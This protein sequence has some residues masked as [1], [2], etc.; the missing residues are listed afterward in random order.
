[1]TT[2]GKK[3]NVFLYT[4]IVGFVVFTLVRIRLERGY[5]PQT[6][7]TV[8]DPTGS[9]WS[10]NSPETPPQTLDKDDNKN[11]ALLSSK[12]P[13]SAGDQAHSS[14]S[15]SNSNSDSAGSDSDFLSPSLKGL[16]EV[17][18][19]STVGKSLALPYDDTYYNDPDA[20]P[21]LKQQPQQQQ[22]QQQ[23]QNAIDHDQ[24]QHNP[25]YHSSTGQ[26][27]G[28]G[29][30]DIA[31]EKGT[32]KVTIHTY[33]SM[34][35]RYLAP[36][37]NRKHI[38]LLEIGLG[39][40]M[41]NG[42]GRGVGSAYNTWKEYFLN[43]DLYFIEQDADCIQQWQGTTADG[44]KGATIVVGDPGDDIFMADFKRQHA[45]TSES[46]GGGGDFDVIVISGGHTVAQQIKSLQSLWSTVRPGGVFFCEYLETSYLE[47]YGGEG[48]NN[49]TTSSR[50]TMFRYLHQIMEDMMYPD[51]NLD[52]YQLKGMGVHWESQ[53]QF[54]EVESI[55]HIDC[56]KQICAISKRAD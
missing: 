19:Q 22:Q 17:D 21:I 37:R 6:E 18:D 32:D 43:V 33:Q 44:G 1:M 56:G 4:V 3:H 50:T 23:N 36:K 8:V 53:A 49:Q 45:P 34:Y 24:L 41:G 46:G 20:R 13:S 40:W 26:G 39:C 48:S 15:E 9:S 11:D 27:S 12:P 38:K 31:I 51:P 25:N 42:G 16:L 52:V 28:S 5:F 55:S 14:D 54:H 7:D 10:F 35:E 47:K 30:Y 2:V 29:F